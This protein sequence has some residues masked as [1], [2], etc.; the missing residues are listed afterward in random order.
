M[1]GSACYRVA[2]CT[3]AA[4]TLPALEYGHGPRCAVTGGYVYRGTANSA[5]QGTYFY[6]DYCPEASCTV[7]AMSA[8][9]FS[10][11][12]DWPTLAPSSNVVSF[13]EDAAGELYL[14]T[15]GVWDLPDC[16]Q[17]TGRAN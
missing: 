16:A 12:R 11:Q 5:L 6:S 4:F 9:P 1:E 2:G 10:D 17:V 13:G 3:V 7:S 8:E 15:R 14:V